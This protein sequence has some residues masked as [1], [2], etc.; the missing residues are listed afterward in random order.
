[1]PQHVTS[2]GEKTMKHDLYELAM[3]LDLCELACQRGRSRFAC[4]NASS[5]VRPASCGMYGPSCM[6]SKQI[7]WAC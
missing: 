5:G 6:L 2:I 1:M 3:K 4:G 7:S